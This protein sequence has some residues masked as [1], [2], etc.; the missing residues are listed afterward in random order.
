MN[1]LRARTMLYT[2]VLT[3]PY[4]MG[5]V[6]GELGRGTERGE[7]A[8]CSPGAGGVRGC[9]RVCIRVRLLVLLIN[10]CYWMRRGGLGSF[11]G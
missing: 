7:R 11:A 4:R 6:E 9:V 1:G 3:F 8:R 5:G 10:A 2:G